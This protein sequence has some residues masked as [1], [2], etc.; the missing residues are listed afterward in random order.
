MA[1][2]IASMPS[3]SGIGEVFSF[4]IA[5]RKAPSSSASG[6]ALPVRNGN[7]SAEVWAWR[8]VPSGVTPVDSDRWTATVWW[9]KS[10]LTTADS[11]VSSSERTLFWPSLLAVSDAVI[12]DSKVS[13][14]VA[15][16]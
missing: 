16:S 7:S 13:K 1:I 10:P 9:S 6:S 5:P 4:R 15:M 14:A 8:W 3:S 2:C 12:P 11:R